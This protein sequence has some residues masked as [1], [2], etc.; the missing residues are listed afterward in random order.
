[1]PRYL[2]TAEFAALCR[3]SPETARFWRHVGKGPKSFKVGRRVLYDAAVVEEWLSAQQN[4]Q[5]GSPA[6]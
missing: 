6:A 4:A 1:M 2:T 3:T 5:T